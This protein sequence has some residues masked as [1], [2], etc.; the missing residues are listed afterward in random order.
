MCISSTENGVIVGG[1]CLECLRE[2]V[3]K[4]QM[5]NDG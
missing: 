4:H 2:E 5:S 1:E 3:K